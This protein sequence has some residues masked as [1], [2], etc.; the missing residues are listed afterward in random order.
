VS[1]TDVASFVT[2]T[3]TPTL[4]VTDDGSTLTNADLKNLTLA[5][6]NR[7][8]FLRTLS[9]EAAVSPEVFC[10]LREDW[11]DADIDN[12]R[13]TVYGV[14]PW[15]FVSAGAGLG[16]LS[17]THTQGSAK[18]PGG[19]RCSCPGTLGD[20]S[21]AFFCGP[22]AG[23][24]PFSFATIDS[25]T[26]V[27]K[28]DADTTSLLTPF[29]RAGFAQNGSLSNGGT[30]CLGIAYG[31]AFGANWLLFKRV[32]SVQTTVVLAP[33][34]IGEYVVFRFDKNAAGGIDVYVNG[35]LTTTVAL[36]ALPAGTCTFGA[37]QSISGA[38]GATVVTP[39]WDL[40]ALRTKPNVRSGV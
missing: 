2:A 35:V 18:N 20:A 12:S 9:A 4:P 26:I 10:V 27:G 15:T 22:G 34:V 19:L 23:S 14:I 5:L 25:A 7:I 21:F 6:A 39:V 1:T 8:E 24:N 28:I 37:I 38:E 33:M 30:D 13:Q 11:L 3:Y 29:V 32:A 16:G 31:P 36:A 40:L 17:I